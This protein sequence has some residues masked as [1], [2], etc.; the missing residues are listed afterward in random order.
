MIDL[1]MI[2]QFVKLLSRLK[3]EKVWTKSVRFK[4]FFIEKPFC[5]KTKAKSKENCFGLLQNSKL[6]YSSLSNRTATFVIWYRYFNFLKLILSF[7][8]YLQISII[9]KLNCV[10]II[11]LLLINNIILTSVKLLFSHQQSHFNCLISILIIAAIKL[12][13]QSIYLK[14]SFTII[15]DHPIC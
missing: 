2:L 3:T 13:I 15:I 11:F 1:K 10:N 8:I 14:F 4:I 7:I 12:Q 9:I 5:Y 6:M